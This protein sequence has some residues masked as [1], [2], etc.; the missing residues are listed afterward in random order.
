MNRFEPSL[1]SNSNPLFSAQEESTSDFDGDFARSETNSFLFAEKTESFVSSFF[2]G[3]DLPQQEDGTV[4]QSSATSSDLSRHTFSD[5]DLTSSSSIPAEDKQSII[6]DIP[7]EA[8]I[9][10]LDRERMLSL[11]AA[12]RPHAEI[13]LDTPERK[14]SES[15]EDPQPISQVVAKR[16]RKKP[17]APENA[18]SLSATGARE[19]MR[20]RA[21][22]RSVKTPKE[23]APPKVA[24][25]ALKTD[26]LYE[27]ILL[28]VRTIQNNRKKGNLGWNLKDFLV[29]K[30]LSHR[31]GP[32]TRNFD[33][34]AICHFYEE[35]NKAIIPLTIL[36]K[37]CFGFVKLPRILKLF[38]KTIG[39]KQIYL[40]YYKS[41]S[42]ILTRRLEQATAA[43]RIN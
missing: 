11:F 36:E 27:E 18:H 24:Q 15:F 22:T 31:G 12:S 35:K 9:E 29:E 23:A 41:N 4:C 32:I 10:I 25:T 19:G 42:I 38:N 1:P 34:L 7:D 5:S 17:A 20:R 30:D 43:L 14:E 26:E 28:V 39:F 40:E 33:I 2:V 6:L 13:S 3:D 8:L 21:S 37:I 16:K